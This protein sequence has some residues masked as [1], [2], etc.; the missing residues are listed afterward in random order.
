M[1]SP[2]TNFPSPLPP[3]RYDETIPVARDFTS[4]DEVRAYDAFHARFR[5]ISAELDRTLALL[6]P[7]PTWEIADIGCG[8]GR[9][10]CRLAPLCRRVHAVDLSQ[11]MLDYAATRARED[12]LQN[13]EYHH[14][15]FLTYEHKGPPLDAAH[16][17]MA[18]HHLP[19]F[20]KQVALTRIHAALRPGAPFVL[21]DISW[22]DEAP[23][24]AIQSWLDAIAATDPD[25]ASELADTPRRE[26]ATTDWILRGLLE[27]AGFTIVSVASAPPCVIHTYLCRA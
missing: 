22:P 24:K 3:W 6:A 9:L 10:V 15:T 18:L 1:P 20:W 23:F 13:I 27:R 26:F 12:G 19:D 11:A 16:T 4:P 21:T 7:Q 25:L 5:N 8:T 17:S 2:S 14:G